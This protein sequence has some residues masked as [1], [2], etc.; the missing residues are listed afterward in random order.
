MA[1][2]WGL[3]PLAFLAG[4][5]IAPSM[6]IVALLV[7]RYAPVSST[8]EAFTWSST[9]IVT[10]VGAGMSLGGVLV[11][12]LGANGAFGLAAAAALAGAVLALSL[13]RAA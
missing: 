1:S 10:G 8:T 12:R 4:T 11:E 13:R 2:P 5:L 3:A 9:A 6:T 7:S